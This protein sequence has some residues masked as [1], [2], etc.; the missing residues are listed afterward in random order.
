MVVG[1][2]CGYYWCRVKVLISST[3][4][5]SSIIFASLQ[6]KLYEAEGHFLASGPCNNQHTTILV[7]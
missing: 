5:Y 4:N 6:T 7:G 3:M 2:N 1:V